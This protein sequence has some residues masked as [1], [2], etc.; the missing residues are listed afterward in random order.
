MDII[1]SGLRL[2]SNRVGIHVK[3]TRIRAERQKMAHLDN[4]GIVRLLLL[5]EDSSVLDAVRLENPPP[6]GIGGPGIR[7][8]GWNDGREVYSVPRLGDNEEE[9]W[10]GSR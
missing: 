4:S 1:S 7:H 3:S 6:D 9:T 8:R 10:T 2:S 5:L